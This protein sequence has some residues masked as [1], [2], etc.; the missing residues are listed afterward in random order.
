MVKNNDIMTESEKAILT[1]ESLLCAMPAEHR[2]LQFVREA[3]NIL[4]NILQGHDN[5][6]AV[7]VGPCS[8]HDVAAARVYAQALLE[9]QQ[10]LGDELFLVMRSYFE[11]PR[12][13]FGWKGLINDPWL[14]GSCDI[15][16]GLMLARHLLLDLAALKVPAGGELLNPFLQM[17]LSDLMSWYAIG[18]RTTESPLHREIISGLNIPAGFKNT[19]EGNIQAA[20]DAVRVAGQSHVYCGMDISG[21]PA[22]IKTQGNPTCHIILRGSSKGPNFDSHSRRQ[23]E[24]SLKEAALVARFMVDCSHGNTGGHFSGQIDAAKTLA[25]HIAEGD[26]SVCGIMLESH[27]KAGRQSLYSAPLCYGQSIT[28]ACI[29]WDDTKAVLEILALSVMKRRQAV[30]QSA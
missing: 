10:N 12:T 8:I 5:R 16:A 26:Q 11:K 27:L 21:H 24:L 17:G 13:N 25:K 15:Q 7:I 1:P 14:N 9:Q 20:I 29:S 6:L 3:Q 28:D 30:R 23:A 2:H 18:A 22:I 19:R 4:R